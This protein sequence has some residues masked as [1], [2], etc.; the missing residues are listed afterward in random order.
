MRGYG[1]NSFD[2]AY[3]LVA[4]SC[5]RGNEASGSENGEGELSDFPKDVSF[6]RRTLH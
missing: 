1:L 4:G 6:S 2:S 3:V 5:E